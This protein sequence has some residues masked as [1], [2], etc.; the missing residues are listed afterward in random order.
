MALWS[1][2]ARSQSS[3]ALFELLDGAAERFDFAAII[4]VK[5]DVTAHRNRRH[6]ESPGHDT[7]SKPGSSWRKSGGERCFL[8]NSIG[9]S[10]LPSH[11]GG[12]I[13]ISF[14]EPADLTD[15]NACANAVA[16]VA[17]VLKEKIAKQ[18]SSPYYVRVPNLSIAEVWQRERPSSEGGDL[19]QGEVV[20]CDTQPMPQEDWPF[21]FA[22]TWTM[23]LVTRTFC[24]FLL[25]PSKRFA[26]PFR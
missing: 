24:T 8:V 15:P 1:D 6:S 26:S 9:N 20:V 21:R 2:D 12:I 25:I 16:S 22:G 7:D 5:D 14:E 3:A 13:P 4:L 23:R 19:Q 10:V 11:L 18:G 17:R